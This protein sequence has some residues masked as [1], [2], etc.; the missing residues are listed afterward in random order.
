MSLDVHDKPEYQ[1][2]AEDGVVGS[3]TQQISV[4]HIMCNLQECISVQHIVAMFVG[5][6]LDA[7]GTILLF[8]HLASPR[9]KQNVFHIFQNGFSPIFCQQAHLDNSHRSN[10]IYIF[11]HK[12]RVACH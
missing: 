6:H 11:K 1:I 3:Q 4:K 8:V 9:S 2:V 10:I 7:V 5:R 12:D